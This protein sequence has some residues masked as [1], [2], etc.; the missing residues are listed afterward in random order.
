MAT[1][2]PTC[3]REACNRWHAR[4]EGSDTRGGLDLDCMTAALHAAE[5]QLAEALARARQAEERVAMAT[6]FNLPGDVV[7]YRGEKLG[8]WLIDGVD[9]DEFD[10]GFVSA[11][12]AFAALAAWKTP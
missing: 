4:R 10:D 2:C 8:R 1:H 9:G 11:D 3:K 5:A 12:A 7:I 6:C